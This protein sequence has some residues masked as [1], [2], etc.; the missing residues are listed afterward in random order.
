MF[1]IYKKRNRKTN[2]QKLLFLNT[3]GN[4]FTKPGIF[5]HR[6]TTQHARHEITYSYTG[7]SDM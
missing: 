3:E 5:L 7:N 6:P 2:W 4:T 1:L